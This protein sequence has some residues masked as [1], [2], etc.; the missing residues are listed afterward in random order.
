MKTLEVIANSSRGTGSRVLLCEVSKRCVSCRLSPTEDVLS[1]S[2]K[3]Y[4]A[5][6]PCPKYL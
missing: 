3:Y 6:S 5:F 1:R 4:S 2:I